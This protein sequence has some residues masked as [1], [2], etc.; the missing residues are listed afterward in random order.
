M[1]A[2]SKRERRKSVVI[3]ARTPESFGV[4][5]SKG[6]TVYEYAKMVIG[7]E[8]MSHIVQSGEKLRLPRGCWPACCRHCFNR[9]CT[10]ALRKSLSKALKFYR[11]LLRKGATTTCGMLAENM[12]AQMR[13]KGGAFNAHKCPELGQLLYDWFI[14]CLQMYKARVNGGLIQQQARFLKNHMIGEGYEPQAL[15]NLEGEAWASW[16]RR[17]RRRLGAVSRKTVKHL[18]VSWKN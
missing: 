6:Q 8:A 11:G 1:S 17:W 4:K 10:D 5:I 9:K 12:P 18:K 13:S 2:S 15:P 14:D 3:G 16:F 7:E